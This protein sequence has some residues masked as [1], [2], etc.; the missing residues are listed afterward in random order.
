MKTRPRRGRCRRLRQALDF[1]RPSKL[2]R[3][4]IRRAFRLFAIRL[5]APDHILWR[6]SAQF[7]LRDLSTGWDIRLMQNEHSVGCIFAQIPPISI[8][9]A[10]ELS[11]L[12][13]IHGLCSTETT[14]IATPMFR[15]AAR[16]GHGESSGPPRGA[17]HCRLAPLFL[18][19]TANMGPSGRML[20]WLL[21]EGA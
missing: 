1:L 2:H 13:H 15:S 9:T 16:A 8:W 3:E 7:D 4:R 10:I 11:R 19:N 5:V 21:S 18:S 20:P 17:G 12:S 14:P 6:G